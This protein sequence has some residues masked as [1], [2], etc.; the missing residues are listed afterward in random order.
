MVETGCRVSSAVPPRDLSQ[1][2]ALLS[3]ECRYPAGAL[4]LDVPSDQ[5]WLEGA[6]TA[7]GLPYPLPVG[8]VATALPDLSPDGL[9]EAYIHR[10][11]V[12]L[13]MGPPGCPG[14]G[15]CSGGRLGMMEDLRRG[16]YSEPR[17]SRSAHPCSSARSL[18]T[19]QSSAFTSGFRG[20]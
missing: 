1:L 2:G 16:G 8:E 13:T 20:G 17:S 11:V 15:E 18:P 5:L 12:D 3:T 4:C 9:E 6:A 10:L 7:A 14:E 19:N